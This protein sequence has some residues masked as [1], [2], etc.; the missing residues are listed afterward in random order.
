MG[1]SVCLFILLCI[2]GNVDHSW[3]ANGAA[4]SN[5][6]LILRCN[7]RAP[8]SSQSLLLCDEEV[9]NSLFV[10]NITTVLY[11]L[12]S[13]NTLAPWTWLDSRQ[14]DTTIFCKK[15]YMKRK[16]KED[17]YTWKA[18]SVKFSAQEVFFLCAECAVAFCTSGCDMWTEPTSVEGCSRCLMIKP[19]HVL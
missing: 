19:K 15:I 8:L 14:A 1:R 16:C 2:P 17:T 12:Y 3:E 10:M 18:G 9:Q 6:V 7:L 13:W 11:V 5:L 4:S